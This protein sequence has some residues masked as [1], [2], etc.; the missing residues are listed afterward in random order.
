MSK[1]EL[2]VTKE[3][4]NEALSKLDPKNND[5]WNTAG[6]PQMDAIHKLLPEGAKFTR[7][8]LIA[9]APDFN[10]ELAV[11][12]SADAEAAAKGETTE[13]EV[14]EEI[15][16]T[17]GADETEAEEADEE[18]DEEGESNDETFEAPSGEDFDLYNA[19]IN[20]LNESIDLNKQR[21]DK[22]HKENEALEKS[23]ARLVDERNQ[24]FPPLSPAQNIQ[25]YLK[26][27]QAQRALRVTGVS[28]KAPLDAALQKKPGLGHRR[29][30]TQG[31]TVKTK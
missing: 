6:K 14:E 8:D 9:I 11:K 24:K 4:V 20:K 19:Q 31:S 16:E 26:Q 18:A 22:L 17:E 29:P 12:L 30:T 5:H 23:V 28:P 25:L 21:V 27:Q 2:K 1:E 7:Q 3:Q 10:R 13:E 15:E